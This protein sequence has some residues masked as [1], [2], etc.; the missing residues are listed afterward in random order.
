MYA[1]V[2]NGHV[3]KFPY[4]VDDLKSDNP[5]VSFPSEMG[6]DNLSAYGMFRVVSVG[7][8]SLDSRLEVAEPNG[9]CYNQDKSR[10][11]TSWSVRPKS[12]AEINSDIID[13]IR[14]LETS[15]TA[16]RIREA[17]LGLDN[18]WLSDLNVK[19]D[20]LRNQLVR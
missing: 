7:P 12:V 4:T 9:C 20:D 1:L 8:P 6:D 19:V 13:E 3:V 15:V 18:G 5:D 14:R 16:R 17:I 10:W 2:F 11:E